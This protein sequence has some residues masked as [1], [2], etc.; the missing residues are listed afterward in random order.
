[1]G[2]GSIDFSGNYVGCTHNC[3]HDTDIFYDPGAGVE[4][5][6]R[7]SLWARG[8]Y[9]YE[10]WTGFGQPANKTV[11]SRGFTFGVS[12]DMRSFHFGRQQQ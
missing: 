3:K 11:Y 8:D 4:Y 7:G 9:E 1:M 2:F 10:L 6:I 12:Y 5:R